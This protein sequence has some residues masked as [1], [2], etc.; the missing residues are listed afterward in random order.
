MPLCEQCSSLTLEKL[1]NLGPYHEG[2]ENAV[3]QK[4]VP[5][6]FYLHADSWLD[7][8]E[9]A[10]RCDLCALVRRALEIGD[11]WGGVQEPKL[12]IITDPRSTRISLRAGDVYFLDANAPRRITLI[13]PDCG[14]RYSG[15]MSIYTTPGELENNTREAIGLISIYR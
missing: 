5:D 12:E 4:E 10:E 3:L 11:E 6:F 7:L 8:I 2:P 14:G 1:S 13:A 15:R 9:R